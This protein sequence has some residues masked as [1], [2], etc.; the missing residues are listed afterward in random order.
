MRS[1]FVVAAAVMVLVAAR[2]DGQ[3][4]GDG[5]PHFEVA[6]I[7][8]TMSPGDAGRAA[9]AA[10]GQLNITIL[11]VEAQ[12]GGR[13]HATA[14]L[15]ALILRAYGI[16]EYQVDGGPKWL[17]T[18]YFEVNAKAERE[19]ASEAEMN[20]MLKSLLAER[21]GL[22]VHVETR[23]APVHTLTVARDDGR[24]GPGLK[25]TSPECEATLEERKR[26]GAK[27]AP[28]RPLDRMTPVCGLTTMGLTPRTGAA[29]Y[30]MGGQPISSLVGRIS[31]ELG[32]AVV[33]QTGLTGLFD[34][35]F[36]Y[37]M[38]RRPAG[39]APPS[40]DPNST[41]PLPVPLPAALQQQLGLRLEK[42]T[43][44]LPITIVDAADPPT[45]D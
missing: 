15:H 8:T 22:R 29:T 14:S 23:Q 28:G 2:A 43:G 37:E 11:G 30:T 40:L 32:A 39:M 25:R 10:G 19:T 9:P 41:D 31:S 20:E 17:T 1:G 21:F 16:K 18:D 42:G 45:P 13:L 7:K 6:S 34:A 35:A 27:V 44:P 5:A 24:L 38:M 33:D 3:P 12:P 36:E 4:A 26:T